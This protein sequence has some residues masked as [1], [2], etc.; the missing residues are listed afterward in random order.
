[1]VTTIQRLTERSMVPELARE[2]VNNLPAGRVT[3]VAAIATADATDL[4]TVI[5]LAN[6]TKAKVNELIAALKA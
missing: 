6:A 4:P 5:T 2:V 3:S 1:M